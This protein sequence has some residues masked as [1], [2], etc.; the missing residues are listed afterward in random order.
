M[1]DGMDYEWE[2]TDLWESAEVAESVEHVSEIGELAPWGGPPGY[3]SAP[4]SVY[5][6]PVVC[7]ICRVFLPPREPV[8][9]ELTALVCVQPSEAATWLPTAA[10][11]PGRDREVCSSRECFKALRAR[12]ARRRRAARRPGVRKVGYRQLPDVRL[13][14]FTIRQG[15]P[16]EWDHEREV[17]APPGARVFKP[18]DHKLTPDQRVELYPWEWSGDGGEWDEVTDPDTGKSAADYGVSCYAA[19]VG[20][21]V[22]RSTI[23]DVPVR[24]VNGAV[25]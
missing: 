17:K 20:K 23:L 15:S 25:V 1:Y 2:A 12:Q 24:A 7:V 10:M 6:R 13:G 21:T 19:E 16:G 9:D 8:C 22:T 4:P 18:A 14:P 11:G 3:V 5:G